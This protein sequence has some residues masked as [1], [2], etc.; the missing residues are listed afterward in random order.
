MAHNL[1]L[2]YG[3]AT[4]SMAVFGMLPRGFYELDSDGVMTTAGSV[5]TDVTPFERAIRIR[6]TALAQTQQAIAED[7]IAR[8]SR[9]RPHQLKLGEMTWHIRGG[10]LP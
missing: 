8:A 3:G 6:Q 1:T 4:P 9:T 7:R 2:N 10:V 5:Q